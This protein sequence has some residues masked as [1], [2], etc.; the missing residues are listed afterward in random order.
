M[1]LLVDLRWKSGTESDWR[2]EYS[3]ELR[4]PGAERLFIRETAG[5]GVGEESGKSERGKLL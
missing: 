1:E 4:N 3:T 2:V 5:K